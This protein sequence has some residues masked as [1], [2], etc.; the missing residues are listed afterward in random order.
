MQSQPEKKLSDAER[1]KTESRY[2]R[3]TIREALA[4]LASGTMSDADSGL[5]KF[6]GSYVQDDRDVRDERARQKLE[7]DFGFMIRVRVPGGVLTPKQWLELDRIAQEY[8][9]GTLRIT[10][11]QTI[12]LHGVS[13]F[14]L[15]ETM[16]AIHAALLNTIA[17]CGDVNRNVM[18]TANPNQSQAHAE[19]L[20]W[21]NR[22]N[23]HFLPQTR[24]YY[25]IWLAGEKVLEGGEDHEPIYGST[26]LP[27]KFKMGVAVPPVNDIDVFSQDL[28]LIAVL[29]NG[30]LSGFNVV[31]GGGM[32]MTHGETGTWPNVAWVIGFCRPEQLLDVAEKV[33]TIQRDFGDRTNRKHARLKYTIDDRGVE[34]FQGELRQRLGWSLEPPREYHFEHRG[35]RYGWVQGAGG[36][37]HLTLYVESGRVKDRPDF[38]QMTGLRAIA[39]VLEGEFRLTANQNVILANV[40]DAQRAQIDA[41]VAQYKLDDG[42]RASPLRRN[43]LSCVSLPLCGLAMAESERYFPELIVK[44]ETLFTEA[45]LG[46]DDVVFRITG[47]PNGCARPFL[48]EFALVGKAPGRYNLYLGGGFVGQ[49]LNKLYRENIAEEEI[50]TELKPIVERYAKERL[51]GERFGDFTIRAGYV[52]EVCRGRDFHAAR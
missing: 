44:L 5:M 24:A 37:W 26:Y 39:A 48:A 1:I 51:P 11:R 22:L 13:K 2:L 25:E 33:V 14:R 49:R 9:I 3:G 17:A 38:P 46:K 47:C 10:T 12:E 34:W 31:V 30:R 4:D 52:T 28:G 20:Q 6:H 8:T 29:E 19:V 45:G 16:Q 23:E 32:G 36:R 43:A 35:D 42:Q 7:P 18:C 40:P 41:L 27:R 50:L 21:C 15:R